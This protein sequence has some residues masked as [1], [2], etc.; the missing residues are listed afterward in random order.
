MWACIINNKYKGNI[1]HICL[2]ICRDSA[3]LYNSY[4]LSSKVSNFISEPTIKRTVGCKPYVKEVFTLG[5]A[6]KAHM[7][8]R[9]TAVILVIVA[10]MYTAFTSE[11]T[12]KRGY[13]SCYY[14]ER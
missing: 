3:K 7:G 10:V 12:Q 11:L 13:E 2:L 6:M 4:T 9:Y 14:S 8:R 1:S 5:E